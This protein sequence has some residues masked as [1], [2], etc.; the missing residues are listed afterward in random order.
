MIGGDHN[1]TLNKNDRISS[2][3]N[4][5]R[6]NCQVKNLKTFIS[7]NDLCDIWKLHNEQKTQFTWRRKNNSDKSRIDFWL[8][9]K[10]LV[11]QVYSTDIRPVII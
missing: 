5:E 9:E 7:R 1:D 10:N 6:E 4:F 8:I 3:N 11:P 2:S